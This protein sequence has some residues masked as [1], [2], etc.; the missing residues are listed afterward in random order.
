MK[1]ILLIYIIFLFKFALNGQELS[2]ETLQ[3]SLVGYWNGNKFTN[4]KEILVI[5]GDKT[6]Q[7]FKN[8]VKV[9]YGNIEIEYQTMFRLKFN[10]HF[11]VFS[12]I[13]GGNNYI[14]KLPNDILQFGDSPVDGGDSF[15]NK[16][17]SKEIDKFWKKVK[18]LREK[19]D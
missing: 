2:S 13:G 5:N 14:W 18:Y 9:D 7:H 4:D 3:T 19:N 6:Y 12:E 8:N 11:G 10:S 17:S 1:N 15:F 16:M